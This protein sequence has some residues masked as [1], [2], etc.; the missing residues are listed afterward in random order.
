MASTVPEIGLG[1][2]P[3]YRCNERP[4]HFAFLGI[5]TTPMSLIMELR[6]IYT[7]RAMRR[8][9]VISSVARAATIESDEEFRY[10]IDGDPHTAKGS[11]TLKTGPTLQI[12][13]P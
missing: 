7:G 2:K 1:F 4:G 12:I 8:D 11:L 3:F 9:K 13:I 10:I 5:H 6:R